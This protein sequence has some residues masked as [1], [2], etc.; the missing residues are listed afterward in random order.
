MWLFLFSI[1]ILFFPDISYA[2]GPVTHVK[3]GLEV[4]SNPLIPPAI[5]HLINEFP[6]YF[7]YGNISADIILWK[8][9]IKYS[10]HCHN[11]KVGF[12]ILKNADTEP[13][14][15]FAYGY[16]SHLSAD[17]IAHNFFIPIEMLRNYPY[18]KG[19][20]IPWEIRYDRWIDGDAWEV[21]K[22]IPKQVD[23]SCDELL[24]NILVRKFFSFKTN[25]RIFITFLTIQRLNRWKL[26]MKREK[27][28]GETFYYYNLSLYA[29]KSVLSKGEDS[30]FVKIDPTGMRVMKK[31]ERLKKELKGLRDV[32]RE[33]KR[34]IVLKKLR[35]Y[36]PY[37]PEDCETL[38]S[39]AINSSTLYAN[40]SFEHLG[41]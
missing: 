20:H 27:I 24:K 4:L 32:L 29:M 28:S 35:E 9:K 34:K 36:Q 31:A 37:L 8:N 38:L 2:W 17:I 41:I 18:K 33:V 19:K 16:L 39:R 25:K 10:K 23:P 15:A 13:L 30:A 14:K 1:L 11:W 40:S 26:L 6:H 12:E 7:L 3:L 22:K 5:F 21:L